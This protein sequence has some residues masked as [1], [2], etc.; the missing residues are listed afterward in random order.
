VEIVTG[1]KSRTLQAKEFR[2]KRQTLFF[3]ALALGFFIAGAAFATEANV[4][5][6]SKAKPSATPTEEL[7]ADGSKPLVMPDFSKVNQA[8][9]KEKSHL[10]AEVLCHKPDGTDVSQGQAGYDSCVLDSTTRK[11]N[12]NM[13]VT[14]PHN[15]SGDPSLKVQWGN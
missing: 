2:L 14:P 5:T 4:K 7:A 15:P 8:P 1:N 9:V 6:E 3:I 13:N 10:K 12:V 11:S